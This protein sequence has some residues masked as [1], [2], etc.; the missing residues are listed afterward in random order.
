M[1]ALLALLIV[2]LA[3]VSGCTPRPLTPGER[4][5]HAFDV[6]TYLGRTY[7]IYAATPEACRARRAA[8]QAAEK[9]R[10]PE[11][12]PFHGTSVTSFCR[13]A[14][15][16]PG[17]YTW[18]TEADGG[19][20]AVMPTAALCDAMREVIARGGASTVTACAPATLTRR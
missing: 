9:S 6:D 20:G 11:R 8:E 4:G 15:L 12:A 13:A 14:A 10:A 1:R 18:A 16:K 2:A 5:V 7:S 17:G 19:W 3:S